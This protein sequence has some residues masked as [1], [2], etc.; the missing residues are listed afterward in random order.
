[1]SA[2]INCGA[3]PATPGRRRTAGSAPRTTRRPRAFAAVSI[4]VRGSEIGHWC[5]GSSGKLVVPADPGAEAASHHVL[6]VASLQPGQLLGEE[7]HALPITAWHPRDVGAPE[8]ALRS[9]RIED[10]VQ[11]V[12]DVLEWIT[13]RRICRRAGCLDGNIGQLG[14]RE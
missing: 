11:S 9:I 3:A 7:G 2:S 10:A 12:L 6:E 5:L 13:L 4:A 14:H 1:M 8:E